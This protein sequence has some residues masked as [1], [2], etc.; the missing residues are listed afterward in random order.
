[1]SRKSIDLDGKTYTVIGV[2][3]ASF[4]FPDKRDVPQCLFAFQLLPK[5]TGPRKTL[6]VRV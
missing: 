5:W 3:P 1:M 4:R 2:L 6:L